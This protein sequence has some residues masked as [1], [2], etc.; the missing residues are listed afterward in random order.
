MC[1]SDL[2]IEDNFLK[3]DSDPILYLKPVNSQPQGYQ[4][5]YEGMWFAGIEFKKS[6]KHYFLPVTCL[7]H[8]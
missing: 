3:N 2:A 5:R 7:Q 4:D 8:N 1:N 6:T